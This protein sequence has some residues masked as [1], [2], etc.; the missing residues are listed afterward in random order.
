VVQ[1]ILKRDE[2]RQRF[3]LSL[4]DFKTPPPGTI[5]SGKFRFGLI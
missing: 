3:Y 4:A 5:N 1:E 2:V